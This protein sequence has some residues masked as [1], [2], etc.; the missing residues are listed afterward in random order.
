MGH[1]NVLNTP[2]L[3]LPHILVFRYMYLYNICSI[4]KNPTEGGERKK[5]RRS[6]RIL[7]VKPQFRAFRCGRN[8]VNMPPKNTPVSCRKRIPIYFTVIGTCGINWSMTILHFV[9]PFIGH[10]LS[11]A[12]FCQMSK[13]NVGLLDTRHI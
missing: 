10:I 12:I 9:S 2:Q 13:I 6:W 1:H 8:I 7:T 4:F 3:H 11:L 5:S